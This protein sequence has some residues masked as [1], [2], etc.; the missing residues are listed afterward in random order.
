MIKNAL[1][2]REKSYFPVNLGWYSFQIGV[3]FLPSSAF[4]S[5]IFLFI[6]LIEGSYKRKDSYWSEYWN[7]PLVLISFVMIIGSFRAHTGWLAF[8]GLF[9]W[10]PFFW[11]FWG[12]QTYL[13]DAH[14]RKRCAFLF[15]AGTVPVVITG[16]GQLWL[17]WEA[18]LQ[19]CD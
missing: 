17:G 10:L 2:L 9:N 5:Y 8:I 19:L 3:F 16:F 13:I 1:F 6:A 11:C 12:F 15:V 7:Y 18:P 4:I 14:A